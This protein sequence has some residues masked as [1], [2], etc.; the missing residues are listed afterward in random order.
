MKIIK[1]IK[2]IKCEVCPYLRWN[3]WPDKNFYCKKFSLAIKRR[4]INSIHNE[5]KLEDVEHENNTTK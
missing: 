1:I 5:C 3:A 4:N 2:I